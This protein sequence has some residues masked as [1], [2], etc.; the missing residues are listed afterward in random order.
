M[1]MGKKKTSVPMEAVKTRRQK[2]QTAKM[3]KHKYLLRHQEQAE[4]TTADRDITWEANMPIWPKMQ[5][6]CLKEKVAFDKETIPAN[7]NAIKDV[8]HTFCKT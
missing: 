2:L 8:K 7:K 4:L 1:T 6:F 5:T 3:H